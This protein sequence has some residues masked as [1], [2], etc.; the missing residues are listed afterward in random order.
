MSYGACSIACGDI[1]EPERRKAWS[2][3]SGGSG[4]ATGHDL[5]TMKSIQ[6]AR[7]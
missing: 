1:G 5:E 3:R 6:G 4:S 2:L 7:R